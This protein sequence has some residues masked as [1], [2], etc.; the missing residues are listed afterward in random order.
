MIQFLFKLVLCVLLAVAAA[1][2]YL[3]VKSGAPRY[4][5]YEWMSPAR[6]HQYDRLIRSVALAHRLDPMLV[7]AVVWRESRFDPKKHGSHGERGLMQVSER[8][9]N[10]W[11]RENKIAG[12]NLDQL[13]E[14]KT[15]LEAGTWYLQRAIEHWNHQSDPIPFALAEYNAGASR[16]QRWSGGNELADISER[17]FLQNI[18]FPATRSY[19]ES[20]IDRYRFYQRRGRM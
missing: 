15:N 6:F 13:F 4:T 8:A 1:F 7:K 18:D 16:A 10:E 3:A 5:V 12:F 14:P 19:V 20:I 17:Q 11:A 9:A 2:A